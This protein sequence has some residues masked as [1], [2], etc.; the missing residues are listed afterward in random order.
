MRRIKLTEK[1][2]EKIVA[3]ALS[4]IKAGGVVVCPTDTVYGLMADAANR[5]AV[6]KIFKIKQRRKNKLLP[7]FVPDIAVAK[8]LAHISKKQEGVLKKC[9]P[10]KITVVLERKP[11]IKLYGLDKKTIGLRVSGSGLVNYL[12]K[13]LK[14]PLVQT[15]VN[16][17]GQP[18]LN[19]PAEIIKEFENRKYRPD[20]VVDAGPIK[21]AK[22]SLVID[23]TEEDDIKILR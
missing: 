13:K 9:W 19:D 17:S 7:V 18:S 20:L 5:G 10:G 23:L 14:K 16:I 22:P 6:E 1:N 2:F 11:G 4:T 12:L 21:S 8:Q 15:S 3:E